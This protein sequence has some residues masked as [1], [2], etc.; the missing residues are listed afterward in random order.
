MSYVGRGNVFGVRGTISS[1]RDSEIKSTTRKAFITD[2][3]F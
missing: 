1:E 2:S 3:P